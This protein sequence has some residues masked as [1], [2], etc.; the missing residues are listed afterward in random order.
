MRLEILA[1]RL[2]IVESRFRLDELQMHQ[3]TGGVVDIDEQRALR[4]AVLEPPML[5]AVDLHQ[6]TQTITPRPRLVDALQ[7][8]FSP[9]PQAGPDHPLPQCLD[10]KVQA[11]K[12]RQLLRRQGRTKI[13][14]ALAH[15]GRYGFAER[16]TQSP[17][18]RAAALGKQ[19]R[20]AVLPETA[21]QSKHLTPL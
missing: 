16:R 11:M 12:L 15:N 6:L 18:A 3:A 10:A 17:V 20:G 13:G 7:A 1:G 19:A 21:Q 4:T 8:V 5:G 2:E 14:V 9:N